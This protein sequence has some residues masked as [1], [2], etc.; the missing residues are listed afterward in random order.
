MTRLTLPP[1]PP[2]L[3]RAAHRL[4]LALAVLA[5][6]ALPAPPTGAQE[7]T[8]EAMDRT[9]VLANTGRGLSS[10]VIGLGTNLLADFRRT[11]GIQPGLTTGLDIEAREWPGTAI[12]GVGRGCHD[13]MAIPKSVSFSNTAGT[14]NPRMPIATACTYWGQPKCSRTVTVR[15]RTYTA[16]RGAPQCPPNPQQ[17]MDNV[18]TG[19]PQTATGTFTVRIWGKIG[20]A[21]FSNT[22]SLQAGDALSHETAANWNEYGYHATFMPGPNCGPPRW[23]TPELRAAGLP[24]YAEWCDF[25]VVVR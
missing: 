23:P 4:P 10:P 18:P 11:D 13:P 8:M 7:V 3:R 1:P 25:T 12:L 20:L 19:T 15:G 21:G 14:Y 5:A 17:G 9:Q 24:P 2:P 6:L 22:H 16:N